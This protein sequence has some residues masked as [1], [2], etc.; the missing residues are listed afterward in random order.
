MTAVDRHDA[1]R[2]AILGP[3]RRP[4]FRRMV[5]AQLCS[6]PGDGITTVALPL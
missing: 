4:R 1:P 3:L 5:S 2:V 6:E